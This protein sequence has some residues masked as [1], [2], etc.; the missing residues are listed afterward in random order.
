M[1]K[2]TAI[3]LILSML[4]LSCVGRTP[5]LVHSAQSGDEGKSCDN[6]ALE[7]SQCE[8]Q[9]AAKLKAAK[10]AENMNIVVLVFTVLFPP[11]V[12]LMNFKLADRK[13]ANA[14]VDRREY[15][16]KMG[17]S[18]RCNFAL[19]IKQDEEFLADKETNL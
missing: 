10:E 11:F 9:A 5:N 13:E 19:N 4:S 16:V 14:L 17:V 1:K 6:L 18:K 2:L 12:F 3:I 8:L 7:V 15:L